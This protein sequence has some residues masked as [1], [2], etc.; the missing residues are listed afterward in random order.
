MKRDCSVK[1]LWEAGRVRPLK[2]KGD[3]IAARLKWDFGK[4][5]EQPY[6]LGEQSA[7]SEYEMG[8]REDLLNNRCYRLALYAA[9]V[10]TCSYGK[11]DQSLG[12]FVKANAR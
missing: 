12:A 1:T 4:P 11:G 6:P 2:P 3:N 10:F 5:R 8:H 9:M 7:W